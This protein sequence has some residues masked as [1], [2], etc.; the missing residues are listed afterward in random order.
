MTPGPDVM[1]IVPSCAQTGS[2]G[3]FAAKKPV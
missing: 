1:L 2:A 3:A